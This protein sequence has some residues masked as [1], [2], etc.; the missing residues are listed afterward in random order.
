M[1]QI[2]EQ[3]LREM[4]TERS[5]MRNIGMGASSGGRIPPSDSILQ[6]LDEQLKRL[7]AAVLSL[8]ERLKPLDC[9]RP[10]PENAA[11]PP[12]AEQG[13]D[14]SSRFMNALEDRA[15]QIGRLADRLSQIYARTEL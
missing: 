4:T 5:L 15:R 2:Y 13:Y 7:E 9:T 1:D 10:Q 6:Q 3:H 11:S 8:D 12:K 14:T